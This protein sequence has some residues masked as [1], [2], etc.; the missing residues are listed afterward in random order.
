MIDPDKAPDWAIWEAM[1]LSGVPTRAPKTVRTNARRGGVAARH[2]IAHAMT[3]VRLAS[4]KD[5]LS[6]AR[7]DY[8]RLIGERAKGGRVVFDV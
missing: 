1:Q 4:K 6:K 3:L 7:L 5:D 2:I 8:A